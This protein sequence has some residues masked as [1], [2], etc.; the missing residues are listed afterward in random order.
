MMTRK[1]YVKIAEAISN[2]SYGIGYHSIGKENLVA[3]LCTIFKED[4]PNFDNSRFVKAC[5]EW[6]VSK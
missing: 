2:T 1:D 6:R 3:Q 4:N 5:N